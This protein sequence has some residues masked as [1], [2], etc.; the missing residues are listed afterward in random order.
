M[1]QALAITLLE[2][3]QMPLFREH[4]ARLRQESGRDGLHFMPFTP[5]APEGPKG[6]DPFGFTLALTELS[7][8][9]CFALWNENGS[10][11]IGH[12]DLTGSPLTTMLHR[13]VLGIGIEAAWCGKGEGQRLLRAA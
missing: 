3:D 1:Q 10:A 7:W 6:P 2:I 8:A 9:R 4:F 5:G 13:C 12:V 11:I